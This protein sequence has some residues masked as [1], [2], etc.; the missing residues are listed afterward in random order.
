MKVVQ[1]SEASRTDRQ[2]LNEAQS[3]VSC[4]FWEFIT[5]EQFG[6]V[7]VGDHGKSN[8]FVLMTETEFWLE[9]KSGPLS[10]LGEP[11]LTI[12]QRQVLT[13]AIELAH[14]NRWH[15]VDLVM[16]QLFW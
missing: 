8:G 1:E 11:M 4:F 7:A 10:E 14:Q 3:I 16:R 2:L 6:T 12:D 5:T 13:D 9:Q 15:H